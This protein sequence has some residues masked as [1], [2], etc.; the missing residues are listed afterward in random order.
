[1]C[2]T[3]DMPDIIFKIAATG[4]GCLLVCVCVAAIAH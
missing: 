3:C 4:S 2:V 1:M